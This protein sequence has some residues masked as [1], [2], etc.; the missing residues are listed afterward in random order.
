MFEKGLTS[1][2]D[3]GGLNIKGQRV[4][5]ETFHSENMILDD[6]VDGS[7][8]SFVAPFWL[9]LRENP[10]A[11]WLQVALLGVVGGDGVQTSVLI[12]SLGS[13]RFVMDV[14]SD[15]LQILEVRP[16]ETNK[17]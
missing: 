8:V 13:V 4:L 10:L 1:R 3:G 17:G 7:Y 16:A 12:Q 5:Q 9:F 6:F 14:M 11:D 15:L 2:G